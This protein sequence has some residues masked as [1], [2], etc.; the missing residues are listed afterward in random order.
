MWLGCHLRNN[1]W[2]KRVQ[3]FPRNWVHGHGAV[4]VC[5]RLP[6]SWFRNGLSEVAEVTAVGRWLQSLIYGA[7]KEG[8]KRLR[9]KRR[10]CFGSPLKLS[11]VVD[12]T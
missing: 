6:P 2:L 7:G 3:I 5:C 12:K 4:A 9:A 10:L 11:A 1:T 8:V